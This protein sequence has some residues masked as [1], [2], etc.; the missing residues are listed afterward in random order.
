MDKPSQTP[1]AKRL[2]ALWTRELHKITEKD[3]IANWVSLVLGTM[4]TIT[5]VVSEF[6]LR[7]VTKPKFLVIFFVTAG[8]LVTVI[9]FVFIVRRIKKS[10]LRTEALK[11]N[12]QSAFVRAL[13]NSSFN[14]NKVAGGK[15]AERFGPE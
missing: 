5:A 2:L 10:A 14:P 8:F 7:E 1:Q 11:A 4:G 9:M 15:H 3:R 13:E 6:G 12:V